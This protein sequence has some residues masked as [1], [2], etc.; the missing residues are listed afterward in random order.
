MSTIL[1][2]RCLM[3]V[4]YAAVEAA[5]HPHGRRSV[6]RR[7]MMPDPID[8]LPPQIR[9]PVRQI[10]GGRRHATRHVCRI[11]KC[12]LRRLR[13][14]K[15]RASRTFRWGGVA[16]VRRSHFQVLNPM[17]KRAFIREPSSRRKSAM[18]LAG[19][20][21]LQCF[22]QDNLISASR[23]SALKT[24]IRS[25]PSRGIGAFHGASR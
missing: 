15:H 16:F 11:R 20:L 13:E 3:L 4:L 19:P 14:Y 8:D 1:T 22:A 12:L 18:R 17:T 2:F 5:R 24:E 21:A 7:S 25:I 6:R 23:A 9:N 10:L